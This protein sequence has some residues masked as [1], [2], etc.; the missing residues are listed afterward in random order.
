RPKVIMFSDTHENLVKKLEFKELD[1][2]VTPIA[3]NSHEL[4][5]LQRIETPVYLICSKKYKVELDSKD[6][7]SSRVLK[8]IGK[9]INTRWV[10]PSLGFKLRSEINQF[11]ES[12]L[13][14]AK[15]VFES[16]VIESITRSIV[17]EV[18]ISF[19]AAILF[20]KR[21]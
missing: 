4:A 20:P 7:S 10:V 21:I 1:V 3:I 11:F 14:S 8:Q 17:D 5:N 2:I 9:D 18:G 19:F 6:R 13:V 16:D 12:H 15:I